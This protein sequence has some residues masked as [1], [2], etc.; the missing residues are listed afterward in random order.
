MNPPSCAR[1]SDW[2]RSAGSSCSIVRGPALSEPIEI[3]LDAGLADLAVPL[4]AEWR[5]AGRFFEIFSPDRLRDAPLIEWF[6]RLERNAASPGVAAA[7]QEA[8]IATDVRDLLPLISVPT[9]VVHRQGDRAIPA[10][11]ARFLTEHITD[12]RLVV[13]PGESHLLFGGEPAEWLEEV[14]QML[15]GSRTAGDAR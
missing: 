9:C 8:T 3:G 6:A 12:A 14:Q 15:T 13:L 1:W 11:H 5:G 4:T 7:L 2:R 10:D